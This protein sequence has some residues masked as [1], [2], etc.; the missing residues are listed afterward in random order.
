MAGEGRTVTTVK[1]LVGPLSLA[2]VFGAVVSCAKKTGGDQ[3]REGPMPGETI[4]AVLQR[5]TEGLMALPGVVGTAVGECEGK[6][7]IKVLVV[8]RTP[9]LVQRIPS[10][11]EGFRVVIEETGEFRALDST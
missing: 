5:H 1:Q 9:A 3:Q 6:P 4:Q 10:T 7:C 11:L 2:I 8:K